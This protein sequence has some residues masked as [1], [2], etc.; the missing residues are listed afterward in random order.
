MAAAI[1]YAD[2][3]GLDAL[4]M[5]KLGSELGVEAMSLYNHV[6]NKDDLFNAVVDAIIE[7]IDT[8]IVGDT[9]DTQ[10]R[11][12]IMSARSVM[13]RHKWAPEV[14]E[15]RTVISPTLMRYYH[16]LLEVM[17]GGG[18]SYDLV[19]H[20]M[21]ALG[22][23]ALGFSQELFEPDSADDIDE[24]EAA[25]NEMLAAMAEELPLFLEMMGEIAHDHPDDTIGWCDDQTEFR[26]ALDLILEGLERRRVAETER[27]V[28][29]PSIYESGRAPAVSSPDPGRREL[30]RRRS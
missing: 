6:A 16:T 11:N 23:R 3:H 1:D 21:H 24:A 13:M 12:L 7:E 17:R 20:A 19:H 29:G 22:S 14:I 18:F 27:E 15:S 30:R 2:T 8:E 26:F 5:R 9:W 25:A 28:S 10:L 4:S